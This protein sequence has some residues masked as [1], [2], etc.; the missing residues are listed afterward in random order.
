MRQNSN[1]SQQN[2]YINFTG[3]E[4]IRFRCIRKSRHYYR[5][6]DFQLRSRIHIFS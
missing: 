2:K 3:N 6:L 1:I 4:N 5:F